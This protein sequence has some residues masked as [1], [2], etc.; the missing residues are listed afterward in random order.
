MNDSFN[1]AIYNRNMTDEDYKY[2]NSCP[3]ILGVP[4]LNSLFVHGGVDP[5]KSLRNQV[6]Y[7]VMNM[8]S[9]KEDGTPTQNRTKVNWADDWNRLQASRDSAVKRPYSDVYYGHDSK[10]GLQLK[11]HT[12]G[13][14]SGCVFGNQLTA[15]ELRSRKLTQVF[16]KK[17]ADHS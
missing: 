12:F 3:K 8:R 4:A 17:Y 13:L 6:P 7:L 9:I 2:L 1:I 16:C 5:R 10:L 11:A 14:D 15:L